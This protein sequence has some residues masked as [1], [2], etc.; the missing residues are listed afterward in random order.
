MMHDNIYSVHFQRGARNKG[1]LLGL[2]NGEINNC[3]LDFFKL[4][5]FDKED[6]AKL[7]DNATD[8]LV[9]IMIWKPMSGQ[10][11]KVDAEITFK[12]KFKVKNCF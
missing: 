6:E 11:L 10:A 4:R 3:P 7:F 8:K 12:S 9:V 5:D 2:W 1:F